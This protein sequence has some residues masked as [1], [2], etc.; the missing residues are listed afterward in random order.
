VAPGD[1]GVD[2]RRAGF[3]VGR[4]AREDPVGGEFLAEGLEAGDGLAIE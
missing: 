3:L 1:G 4:L 2:G